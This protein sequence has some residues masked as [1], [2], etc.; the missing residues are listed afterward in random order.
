M[1]PSDIKSVIDKHALW[2][3]SSGGARADLQNADLQNADLQN[4]YLQNAYLQNADLRGADLRGA[5]LQNADLRGAYLRDAD[6]RGVNLRGANL[7]GADLRGADLRGA[8]LRDAN[9]RDAD[10]QGV[11][12][13]FLLPV[14]DP[15]GW[16][17]THAVKSTDGEWLIC[18]GCRRLSVTEALQ[19]WGENYKGRR[20]IGDQYLYAINWL[21]TKLENEA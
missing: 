14:G 20:D 18:A 7:R 10:L 19:H 5:D 9:L 13:F 11:K 1:N 16:S 21:V 6:L 4:A 2:L 17:F 12:N 3:N 8:D 15:R